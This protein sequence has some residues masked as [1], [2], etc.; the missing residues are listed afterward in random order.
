M[1]STT[2]IESLMRD[3]K[4]AT[5]S[6]LFVESPEGQSRIPFLIT[7]RHVVEGSMSIKIWIHRVNS[8]SAPGLPSPSSSSIEIVLPGQSD[9]IYHP[10]D[11]IDLCAFP[12]GHILNS[13]DQG[14]NPLYV[15]C[16]PEEQ[17]ATSENLEDLSMVEEVTMIGY[18]NGLWDAANNLPLFRKGVTASHPALDF[19]GRSEFVIDAACYKGSSGSPVFLVN[20]NG[21]TDKKG[22]TFFGSSRLHLLGLLYAGPTFNAQGTITISEIPTIQPTSNTQIM[23]HLG[24]VIKATE[25]KALARHCINEFK[26]KGLL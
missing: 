13:Y 16:F 4:P 8:A 7:N 18:P 22:N 9:W 17:F 21:W 23:L 15:L 2:R 24:Y 19:E 3:G 20:E 1:F 26:L 10:K 25:I 5:G 6:G 14:K 12:V 11:T